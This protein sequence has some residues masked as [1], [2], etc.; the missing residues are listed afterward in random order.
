MTVCIKGVEYALATTLRVAYKIQ[1][2]HNHKPYSDIFASI[3]NMTLE[4]QVG[5]LYCA[6]Q[7]ANPEVKITRQEF[8]DHCLDNYTLKLVLEQVKE[9][10]KGIMGADDDDWV[11]PDCGESVEGNFC[12]NC[13]RPRDAASV[14]P[15]EGSQG[16]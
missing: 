11:C 1:G 7:V 14:A 4:D 8:L 15:A 16:N 12:S 9:V 3:G 6:F 13:G 10:I 2:Q 5:I